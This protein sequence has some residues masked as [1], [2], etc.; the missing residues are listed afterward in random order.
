[1]YEE[2]MSNADGIM[3]TFDT[4]GDGTI[5]QHTEMRP[6]LEKICEGAD[7]ECYEDGMKYFFEARGDKLDGVQRD[8]VEHWISER[9]A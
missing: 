3:A 1:M 9:D 8:E 4:D 6:V 7:N 5:W 2:L